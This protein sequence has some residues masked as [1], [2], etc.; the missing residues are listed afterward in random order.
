MATYVIGDVQG[1]YIQLLALL[2]KIKYS[3]SDML[4]FTGDLVN[5]GPDSLK[6][7]AFVRS[8]GDKAI[9]VLGNHDLGMLAIIRGFEKFDADLHTFGDILH[10][11]EKENLCTWLEQFPLLHHD[12]ALG[13]TLVHAGIYPAWDLTLATTLAREI[14][15]VLQGPDK[16]LFYQHLYGNTPDIWDPNLRGT[17]RWRFIV[18]CFTRLRFCSIEGQ[19]ELSSK[20]KIHNPP[21]GFIPW[22]KIPNRK[23][24]NNNI[25]FGH[26]AALG[27]ETH[28]PHVFALDT[29]CAWGGCLTA[30]RLEDGQRFSVECTS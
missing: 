17:D 12:A 5:R 25:I 6:V 4:W 7:L 15:T 30:M 10:S 28:T 20:G 18:N 22:F 26:W 1:C 24:E 27:G 29:G 3:S 9:V 11:P 2:E 16:M 23:C 14:E 19:L 13:Y 8:L 21:A